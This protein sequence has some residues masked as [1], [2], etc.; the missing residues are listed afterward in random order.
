[1]LAFTQLSEGLSESQRQAADTQ[2]R[3]QETQQGLKAEKQQRREEG[4]DLKNQ[5][6][7]LHEEKMA[8]QDALAKLEQAHAAAEANNE[9]LNAYVPPRPVMSLCT[10][11]NRSYLLRSSLA[12][13]N[14]KFNKLHSSVRTYVLA[15]VPAG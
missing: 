9:S 14:E 4:A 12:A 1:L 6:S 15:A 5:L 13:L 11:S 8:V 2:R 7:A 10:D 3:L